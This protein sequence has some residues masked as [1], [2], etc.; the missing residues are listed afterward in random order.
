MRASG[1]LLHTACNTNPQNW[2]NDLGYHIRR[3]QQIVV[4][5]F[6]EEVAHL[7]RA[8]LSCDR[9]C[10]LSLTALRTLSGSVATS[11]SATIRPLVPLHVRLANSTLRGVIKRLR[12]PL[13]IMLVCVRS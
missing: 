8:R 1:S 9:P 2:K 10:V 11:R 13:E 5:V 3:L 7:D 12:F 6:M 4:A